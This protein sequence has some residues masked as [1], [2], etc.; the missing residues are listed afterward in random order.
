MARSKSNDLEQP[1]LS[2]EEV[3]ENTTTPTAPLVE[4]VPVLLL[5]PTE[6]PIAQRVLRAEVADDE[7]LRVEGERVNDTGRWKDGLF[8]FCAHGCCHPSY[9]CPMYCPFVGIGQ[10]MG[11]LNLNILGRRGTKLQATMTFFL[12][13]TFPVLLF[14]CG[15][16]IGHLEPEE[17]ANDS[18]NRGADIY[19][20]DL[21][22]ILSS[23]L[24]LFLFYAIVITRRYIKKRDRIADGCCGE[25]NDCCVTWF[26]PLCT[27]SQMMRH[28]ADYRVYRAVWISQ[29]GLPAGI[30]CDD[31]NNVHAESRV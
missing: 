19:L 5:L 8:N 11:R 7:P 21:N 28:T 31:E 12:L 9:V 23:A 27:I 29:T 24:I 30:G 10:V 6:E 2:K 18:S 16:Q 3:L 4:T 26:F 22:C 1:L 25:L 17:D 20:Y 15:S 13:C 14:Y